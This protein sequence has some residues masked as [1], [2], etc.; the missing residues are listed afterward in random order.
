MIAESVI[1]IFS[2]KP[3]CN[4]IYIT[5]IT[6][7][8]RVSNHHH[9]NQIIFIIIFIIKYKPFHFRRYV[10]IVV[11]NIRSLVDI[12]QIHPWTCSTVHSHKLITIFISLSLNNTIYQHIIR[13]LYFPTLFPQDVLEMLAVSFV[14]YLGVS[15][16]FSWKILFCSHAQS[17]VRV[18]VSAMLSVNFWP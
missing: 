13:L 10:I 15:F 14:F 4:D 7:N 12:F 8:T 17:M 5:F 2:L 18:I 1:I 3:V 6:F 11:Y 9:H 16:P